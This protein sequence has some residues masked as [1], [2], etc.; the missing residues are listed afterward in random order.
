MTMRILITGNMGYIGPM[1]VRH[2]RERMPEAQLIG[3]DAAFFAH[4]LSTPDGLPEAQLHAQYFGDMRD[5]PASLLEGVDAVVHLAAI[6]NDPMGTKWEAAT[7]EINARAS[8]RL[9]ALAHQAGVR[10]FVVASSCSIYGFAEGG[11]RRESDTLNPL[12]A[13]ARSKVSVEE[14]LHAMQPQ[15]MTVTCLRFA[16]AC[17][18]SPRLRLDLVL[19]DFVAGAMAAREITVLSDGSP[20]RPLIE[21]RDMAR[22]IE[23]A[24]GREAERGGRVLSVN[25]GSDA[26]NLQVR[27]IAEAVAK[28]V[29]GT[30]VSINTAALPDRRS[31]RVDFSLYRQLAPQHQPRIGLADA[32]RGLRDGLAAIQFADAQFR[33]G[34]YMRLKVLDAL[35]AGGGLDADL[36]RVAPVAQQAVAA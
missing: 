17:G 16:T 21:V 25:V 24:I 1:V 20:W 11:P 8:V 31:Y 14:S 34:R 9:A 29:P 7:N 12:T 32:V 36:R 5:L 2:L 10:A 22:A 6:S 18:M 3:Y 15:T 27:D 23:W 33:E 30:R 4:C 13:Y 28:E 26:W 19:N 35:L